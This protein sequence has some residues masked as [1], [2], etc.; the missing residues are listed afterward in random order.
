MMTLGLV[1]TIVFI[2]DAVRLRKKVQAFKVLD[3]SHQDVR[4]DHVLLTARGYSVPMATVTRAKNYAQRM[5]LDVL[6]L[7]PG[8]WHTL[9]ALSIAQ[10][11]DA[12]SYRQDRL[13]KGRSAGVACLVR[14]DLA[15]RI[16]LP[17][18]D[19]VLSPAELNRLMNTLKLYACTTT[20]IV[21]CPDFKVKTLDL[22]RRRGVLSQVVGGMAIPIL[23][24]QIAIVTA[25]LTFA[26][27]SPLWGGFALLS[28]HLQPLFSLLGSSFRCWDLVLQCILRGPWDIWVSLMTL[29]GS[30]EKQDV[31]DPIPAL[32][33]K[34]EGMV[35]QGLDSLFEARR[36][37]CPLCE[38]E[39]LFQRLSTTDLVQRK[40]GVFSASTNVRHVDIFSK[41]RDSVSMA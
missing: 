23:L 27:H 33:K 12:E 9:G 18:D 11:L 17:T 2:L 3:S 5:G 22:A 14:R 6:D 4:N 38:S 13:A 29:F 37:T 8:Q 19:L 31:Q 21:V 20:D 36:T 34:Y 35:D 16:E 25:L 28:F 24:G 10:M 39:G 1:L 7:V 26:V 15:E 30:P 32:R 40:P 41:T